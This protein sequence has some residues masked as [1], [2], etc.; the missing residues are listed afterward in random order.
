M[1]TLTM[2]IDGMKCDGCADRITSLL[3]KEPGVRRAAVTFSAG[4]GQITYNPHAVEEGR[5]LEVVK[6]AGFGAEGI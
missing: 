4:E 5:I 6:Q 1:Q 3:E 2:K